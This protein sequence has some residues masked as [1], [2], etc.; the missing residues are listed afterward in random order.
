MA[1]IATAQSPVEVTDE[2]LAAAARSGDRQAFDTLVGRYRD[3]AFAYALSHLHS[4]EEAEDVTQEAFV[5]ALLALNRFRI[6]ASWAAWLMRIVRNLCRD[7]LRRRRVR[8]SVTLDD[9]W[10]DSAPTPD[11]AA[12]FFERCTELA[13]AIAAS[14]TTQK[15]SHGPAPIRHRRVRRMHDTRRLV[16]NKP[17]RA[18]ASLVSAAGPPSAQK[19]TVTWDQMASWYEYQGDYRS[20]AAAYVQAVRES[21]TDSRVFNAGRT[22][23]CAGDVAQAIE[24]YARF[25]KHER[26]QESHSQQEVPPTKG[27]SLWNENR[28][29]A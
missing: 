27:T 1:E 13:G 16:R 12:L 29:S 17:N 4:R 26:E 2:S 7:A 24:Y 20:A 10:M 8:A 6:Q 3:I 25:L 21:P 23:E 18:G 22:S 14:Q 28:D 11:M 19:Q 9:R 15:S 5:R